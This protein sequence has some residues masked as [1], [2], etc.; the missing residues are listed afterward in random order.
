MFTSSY[1]ESDLLKGSLVEVVTT[2][3]DGD[4]TRV[5]TFNGLHKV[6]EEGRGIWRLKLHSRNRSGTLL[7]WEPDRDQVRMR[8]AACRLV[9]AKG[10]SVLAN[11][12]AKSETHQLRRERLPAVTFKHRW[13]AQGQLQVKGL[14]VAGQDDG[15]WRDVHDGSLVL[16]PGITVGRISILDNAAPNP[17]PAF[18]VVGDLVDDFRNMDA[19]SRG[20]ALQDAGALADF[21]LQRRGELPTDSFQRFCEVVKAVLARMEALAR[22]PAPSLDLQRLFD[23]GGP[24]EDR[25]AEALLSIRGRL[26]TAASKRPRLDTPSPRVGELTEDLL[27]EVS[28]VLQKVSVVLK[29]RQEERR[30]A[31]KELASTREA[32]R[33]AQADLQ[34]ERVAHAVTSQEL[35]R[36]QR[37]LASTT[38]ALQA[39]LQGECAAHAR[40][41]GSLEEVS[42]ERDELKHRLESLGSM[43][44]DLE[45]FRQKMLANL[46]V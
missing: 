45:S 22:A 40:T 9:D 4:E 41:R 14:G 21:F 1:Q 35:D 27:G 17:V 23:A 12:L 20:R 46:N 31:Q 26:G 30:R 13:S 32:L 6:E 43:A 11:F 33:I 25:A 28:Q 42:R 16:A 19:R 24:Q 15:R 34:G 10:E 38:E 37:E 18:D 36:T 5:Y 8:L 29:G 44:E 7:S 39:D 3:K 2:G